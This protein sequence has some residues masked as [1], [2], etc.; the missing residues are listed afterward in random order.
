MANVRGADIAGRLRGEE[1]VL[2]LPETSRDGARTLLPRILERFVAAADAIAGITTSFSA[3]IVEA[4]AD[5]LDWPEL[6]KHANQA[7]CEA[8]SR[9]KG[10][11]AVRMKDEG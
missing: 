6:Y 11:I 9:G 7:L 8:K 5:G 1:F 10:E 2:Y 3:A 4:P